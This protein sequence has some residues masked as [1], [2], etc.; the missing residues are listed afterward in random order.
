[1]NSKDLTNFASYIIYLDNNKKPYDLSIFEFL[2]YQE[3]ENV[4]PK[5][6]LEF[7]W[8]ASA[9]IDLQLPITN[10]VDSFLHTFGLINW[11]SRNAWDV[12]AYIDTCIEYL[13]K[14]TYTKTLSETYIMTRIAHET[15]VIDVKLQEWYGEAND[16]L[17]EEINQVFN[18][19]HN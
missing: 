14:Q 12:N 16:E 13:N 4:S 6:A 8:F 18:E 10:M 1:M 11:F 9:M 19:C 15:V 3:F 5:N 17:P 2:K 7:S